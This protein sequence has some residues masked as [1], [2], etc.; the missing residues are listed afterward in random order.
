[1]VCY[2][3]NSAFRA[4]DITFLLLDCDQLSHAHLGNVG[5]VESTL[6]IYR[7]ITPADDPIL[8]SLLKV[9][10]WNMFCYLASLAIANKD[11][12]ACI[13]RVKSAV[14]V[15]VSARG[16]AIIF[17]LVE[18][19]SILVKDL[20]SMV[21]PVP[22]EHASFG[23]YS[24]GVR[25]VELALYRHGFLGQPGECIHAAGV[26]ATARRTT[27]GARKPSRSINHCW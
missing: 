20:N 25:L 4:A 19:A 13:G 11:T 22:D 1:M 27:A 26:S 9:R 10:M 14:L 5:H 3:D 17:P 8:I 7:N 18:I 2:G 21:C 6:E 12:H 16:T 23:I 24:D 15:D